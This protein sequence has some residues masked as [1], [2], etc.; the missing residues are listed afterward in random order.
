MLA[1]ALVL[2]SLELQKMECALAAPGIDAP[3]AEQLR[4]QG[5]REASWLP[6]FGVIGMAPSAATGFVLFFIGLRR[7]ASP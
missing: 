3:F 2:W 6:L 5:R 4:T 1:L 7:K